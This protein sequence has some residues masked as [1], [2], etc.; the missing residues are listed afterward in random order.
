MCLE[1]LEEH[2]QPGITV[3]DVGTGSGILCEAA[4]LLGAKLVVAC[5]IDATAAQIA[6]KN[7]ARSASRFLVYTGSVTAIADATAG[8]LVA[9]ISPDWIAALARE[10]SRVLARR[11][12]LAERL[13]RGGSAARPWGFGASRSEGTGN[14]R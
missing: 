5:D 11:K 9:N 13:R 6:Q 1:W 10:W 4:A 14:A 3:C 8:L 12:R 7:I 2:V